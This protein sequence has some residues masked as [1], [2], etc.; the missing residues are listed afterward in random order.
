MR[1]NFYSPLEHVL[2]GTRCWAQLADGGLDYNRQRSPN[3]RSFSL[4]KSLTRGLC[5]CRRAHLPIYIYSPRVYAFIVYTLEKCNTRII[6]CATRYRSSSDKLLQFHKHTHS[7]RCVGHC[8]R[9]CYVLNL[10]R[11]HFAG[12]S[13]RVSRRPSMS[14]TSTRMNHTCEMS[15]G[16]RMND[17]FILSRIIQNTS[18]NSIWHSPFG[19]K[20]SG[21]INDFW[22]WPNRK[23]SIL[24]YQIQLFFCSTI[25]RDPH[26]YLNEI[27]TAFFHPNLS[28]IKV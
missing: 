1:T 10:T 15:F 25:R 3:E 27:V 4:S 16:T 2:R 5:L 6:M 22:W 18:E 11:S 7:S 17:K 24:K 14:K 28:A 23:L 19:Q 21:R 20:V 8:C 9:W 13:L 12:S 26:V